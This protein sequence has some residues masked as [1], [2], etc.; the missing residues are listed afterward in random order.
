MEL[1]ESG[2]ASLRELGGRLSAELRA[3]GYPADR[4]LVLLVNKNL[5]KV[6]GHYVTAWGTLPISLIV[7][8]EVEARSAQ[9][10]RIGRPRGQVVPVSFYGLGRS[11][12]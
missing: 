1:A 11:L 6:L 10:V 4:P 9:Y 8:D 7:I 2:A 3:W 12:L 5:G